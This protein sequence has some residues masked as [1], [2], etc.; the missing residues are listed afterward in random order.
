MRT[1]W[2]AIL[3]LALVLCACG[4]SAETLATQ[5]A[6]AAEATRAAEETQAQAATATAL[7]AAIRL[8]NGSDAW[9]WELTSAGYVDQIVVS[10]GT[11]QEK[12]YRSS[13]D[14]AL[15]VVKWRGVDVPSGE[16][17]A[18]FD[19][20]NSRLIDSGGTEYQASVGEMVGDEITQIFFIPAGMS[21]FTFRF[22]DWPVI[23]LEK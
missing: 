15:Y 18:L 11:N 2:I 19:P 16:D 5:T 12:T 20:T 3:L 21:G 13:G 22:K 6:Q 7:A 9:Y 10:K 4:P 1:Y 14:R 23:K 8:T 17:F